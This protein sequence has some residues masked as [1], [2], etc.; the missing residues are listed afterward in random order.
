MYS[1]L[2]RMHWMYTVLNSQTQI[3]CRKTSTKFWS[4]KEVLSAHLFNICASIS[5]FSF[6]FQAELINPAVKGT[7]NVLN[8]CTKASTVKRVILTSS[9][10]TVSYTEQPKTPDTVV[11]ETWFSN[12]EYLKSRNVWIYVKLFLLY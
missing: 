2:H 5:L 1:T 9:V 11:D 3:S 12:P 8:S 10:A 6:V 7:L 4:V